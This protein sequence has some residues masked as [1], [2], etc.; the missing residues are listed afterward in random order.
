M[1]LVAMMVEDVWGTKLV[2]MTVKDAMGTKLLLFG[3][4]ASDYWTRGDTQKHERSRKFRKG[5]KA[6]KELVWC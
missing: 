3:G 1:K 4:N 6:A 2:A 5:K